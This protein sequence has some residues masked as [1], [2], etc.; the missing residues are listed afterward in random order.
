MQVSKY[1]PLTPELKLARARDATAAIERLS[2]K[3][4][5]KLEG[6]AIR[7]AQQD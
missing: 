5:L 2:T 6:R 4:L 3:R 7:R 1:A